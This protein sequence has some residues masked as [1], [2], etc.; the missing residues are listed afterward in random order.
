MIVDVPLALKVMGGESPHT[1]RDTLV[2]AYA[3]SP[4]VRVNSDP[5]S[6]LV[7]LTAAVDQ[8]QSFPIM[9]MNVC[10]SRKPPGGFRD[11]APTPLMTAN[12]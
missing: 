3:S 5:A 10:F 8:T 7:L 2:A 4:V 6:E 9:P 11:R 12:G 1:L